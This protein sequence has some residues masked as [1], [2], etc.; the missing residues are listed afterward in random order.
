MIQRQD[1]AVQQGLN[2]LTLP[3]SD[4][5]CEPSFSEVPAG[6]VGQFCALLSEMFVFFHVEDNEILA[7][8]AS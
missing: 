3:N 8:Y 1:T 6:S 4:L 7:E 2:S 5:G